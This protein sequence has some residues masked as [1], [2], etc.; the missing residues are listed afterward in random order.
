MTLVFAS[1]GNVTL[2]SLDAYFAQFSASAPLSPGIPVSAV[3][4]A[5]AVSMESALLEHSTVWP[6]TAK[7]RG[8][9]SR[10]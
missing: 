9:F 7:H 10:Q 6:A 5:H 2:A 3:S 1:L 8:S 4:E